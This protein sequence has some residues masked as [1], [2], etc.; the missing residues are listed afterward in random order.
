MRYA[1][2]MSSLLRNNSLS[3]AR[4]GLGKGLGFHIS[5]TIRLASSTIVLGFSSSPG[6]LML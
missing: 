2:T 3:A 5:H 1:L 4:T 6:E